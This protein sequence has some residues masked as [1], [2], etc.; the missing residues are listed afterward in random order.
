MAPNT[1]H[2]SVFDQN[3]ARVFTQILHIFPFPDGSQNEDATRALE[4]GLQATLCSFPFLAGTIQ[5]ADPET[6]KL[7]L[8]YSSDVPNVR[9]ARLFSFS[10]IPPSQDYP[11]TYEQLKR[12]GMPQRAFTGEMFCP[13]VLRDYPG[14]PKDAEGIM[15]SKH[16][17][18][19]LAVEAFFI[20]G[21]LVLSTYFH[22]SVCDGSGKNEFWKQFA[23]HVYAQRPGRSLP[24]LGNIPNQSEL[25]LQMDRSIPVFEKPPVSD[26]YGMPDYQ[27]TLPDGVSCASRIFVISAD[28][29]RAV[30]DELKHSVKTVTPLTRC[31]VLSAL[32]WIHVTRARRARLTKYGYD[33]TSL[34][35]AVDLRKRLSPPLSPSYMGNMALMAKATETIAKYGQ[36]DRVTC[37]TIIPAIK[38]INRAISSVNNMWVQRHLGYFASNKR[39]TNTEI[40]L[41]FHRG[42]DLYITSW[43]H[44]GAE[45]E[46]DIPGTTSTMPEYIRRTHSPSD[47][48]MI[49][50]PRKRTV[51]EN[52]KEAPYEVLIRLAS[53][54]M[55]RLLNE[56]AGL[57]SWADRVIE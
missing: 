55:E 48:G 24:C 54:D 52:G 20:P 39:I 21:G 43:M 2:L 53:E 31:N 30:R 23:A 28:R 47:G 49:I 7:S 17:V 32:I 44:F 46:W 38:E 26:C 37:T 10:S 1:L 25:R 42:P 36:E 4:A 41:R 3:I 57:A 9:T 6:G 40:K 13:H 56:E 29:I 34:G 22:H 27:K 51:G 33:D 14:I 35:I 50:L 8:E 45:F 19:A 5:P 18:P 11:Y 12:D 15:D 16:P